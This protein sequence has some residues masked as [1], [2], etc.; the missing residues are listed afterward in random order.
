MFAMKADTIFY[1]F[2]GQDC[3]LSI[4][5]E[6][7][8]GNILSGVVESQTGCNYPTVQLQCI[9]K[10]ACMQEPKQGHLLLYGAGAQKPG[11]PPLFFKLP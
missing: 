6:R 5:T 4:F 2:D 8:T 7:A 1:M 9:K 3:P 11:R 10:V